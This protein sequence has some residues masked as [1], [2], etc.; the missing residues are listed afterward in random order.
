MTSPFFSDRA[1]LYR[2]R[3]AI[4]GFGIF[5]SYSAFTSRT[6]FDRLLVLE[7]LASRTI[8]MSRHHIFS[9]LVSAFLSAAPVF[10]SENAP[11]EQVRLSVQNLGN[12]RFAVREQ[13]ARD[14]IRTGEPALVALKT[15][16]DSTDEEVR[17]RAETIVRII[18]ARIENE[19]VIRAPKLRLKFD[20][21]PL[22]EAIAEVNRKTGLP[23]ALDQ[24][25]IAMA[26]QPVTVDT[27]DVPF[28]EA[29]ER[30]LAA[31]VLVENPVVAA[32]VLTDQQLRGQRRINAPDPRILLIKCKSPPSA[33]TATLVR[34]KALPSSV[35]GSSNTKGSNEVNLM[36]DV[37]PSPAL[38]W[39]GLANIE[40]SRAVDD[41]EA[42]L[43]QSHLRP[44]GSAAESIFLSN[45]L[46]PQVFGGQVVFLKG[47]GRV[48]VNG[49]WDQVAA[50]LTPG[51]PRHVRVTLLGNEHASKTLKEL[52]GVVTANVMSPP[53]TLLTVDNLL[54][55]STKEPIKSGNY[56]IQIM[57]RKSD[58]SNLNLRFRLTTSLRGD[59]IR[60]GFANPGMN[61]MV[62]FDAEDALTN[63]Q[64]NIVFQ[65]GNGNPIRRVETNVMD[66][67]FD[68]EHQIT[69]YVAN[70][71]VRGAANSAVKLVLNGR[72]SLSIEVPFL[73]KNV[74]LP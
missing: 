25:A 40:I 1:N 6:I 72:K 3:N 24:A 74:P 57:D 62:L 49:D 19:A 50:P 31:A 67:S 13:A 15:A 12:P 69:D 70:V 52:S 27:G 58:K 20:A 44:T 34:V 64:A 66:Q 60:S 14:L 63:P 36:L 53:L 11:P 45:N 48:I 16:V 37:T 26:K 56:Q 18:Q 59:G 30:F 33:A 2:H 7:L 10:A 47:G 55:A 28:W 73:L 39:T 38:T 29:V 51:N 61:G 35:A 17:L 65:D 42:V 43:A 71:P 23:F 4:L 54:T 5:L 68:G 9:A 21:M 41:R 8:D 32:H 46:Q 22:D